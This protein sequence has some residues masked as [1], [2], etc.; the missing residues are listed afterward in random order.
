MNIDTLTLPE[1]KKLHKDVQRAIDSYEARQKATAVAEL[2]ALA[3]EHGFSLAELTGA[4]PAKAKTRAPAIAKYRNPM[5]PDETWSGRG[6]P[7]RW[8]SAALTSVGASL[9]DFAI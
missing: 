9:E 3:K 2:E 4:A 1:L 8:L 6:R 7:P 5:N